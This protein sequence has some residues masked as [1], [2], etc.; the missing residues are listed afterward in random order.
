MRIR[1]GAG[2]GT[3]IDIYNTSSPRLCYYLALMFATTCAAAATCDSIN[4][5]NSDKSTGTG[6]ATTTGTVGVDC[7]VGYAG[8]TNAVCTANGLTSAIFVFPDCIGTLVYVV[9]HAPH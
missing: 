6:T 2:T 4:V 1:A 8:D 3:G 7:D 9:T 5:A